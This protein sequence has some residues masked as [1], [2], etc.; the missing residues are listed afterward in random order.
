[1]A[2]TI[3]VHENALK[4]LGKLHKQDAKRILNFLGERLAT[5]DSPRQI[6]AA[7]QG[8]KLGNYWRYRV[9]DYRIICHLQDHKLIVLVIDIGH[10]R[11]IY[12]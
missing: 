9:G 3:E 4:Q 5:Y 10:R 12:R 2:W 7:L 1:M 11:D 6:G 8:S